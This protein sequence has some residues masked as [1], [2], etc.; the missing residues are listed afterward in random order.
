MVII[1]HEQPGDIPAIH[2][3]NTLAFGQPQE[4]DL[5]DALRRAGALTI[6]LVAVQDDRIVG[7]IAF[8][9]VTITSDAAVVDAIGLAPM[10]VLP[11][12]QRQSIGSQ[13]VEAGLQA[14]RETGYK[15]VVVLGHP[16]YRRS[17]K[18]S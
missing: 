1:R 13:L 16:N 9:P 14:C 17:E 15:I 3:V 11:E 7:H 4:V 18:D 12:R 6:S 8:S 10:A 5:V 2:Q